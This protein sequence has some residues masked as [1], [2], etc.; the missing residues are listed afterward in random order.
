MIN[1]PILADRPRIPALPPL[2][3]TALQEACGAE[4]DIRAI[5]DI[6]A[7]VL[8]SDAVEVEEAIRRWLE[9]GLSAEGLIDDYIPAVARLLGMHWCHDS[10]GFAEVTIA[11][12]RLQGQVRTLDQLARRPVAGFDS[13][14]SIL[15]VIAPGNYHTLGSMI[16]LSRFRRL[17]ASVRLAIVQTPEELPAIIQDGQFDMVTLSASGCEKL[18]VL[19]HLVNRV[20]TSGA[21]ALPIVVGGAILA[22]DP[23]AHIHIGAD[24]AATEPEEAFTA[25]GLTI[26]ITGAELCAAEA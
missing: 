18:E 23:D 11:T 1:D 9:R 7:A 2:E 22:C 21:D 25:C 5:E 17:G 14:P 10:L 20:R 15:M 26:P 13:A 24:F 19:R 4:L 6:A 12:A 8:H 3:P 16:A